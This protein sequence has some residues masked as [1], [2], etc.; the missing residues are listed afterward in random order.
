MTNGLQVSAETTGLNIRSRTIREERLFKGK[1][2]LRL[3][4]KLALMYNSIS[5]VSCCQVTYSY[6]KLM[7]ICFY[8]LSIPV[9]R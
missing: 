8:I 4:M 2:S 5:D 6:V 1:R 3:E 9:W 7:Q